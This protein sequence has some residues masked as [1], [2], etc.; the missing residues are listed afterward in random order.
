MSPRSI[1][2]AAAAFVAAAALPQAAGATAAPPASLVAPG[3]P[4]VAVAGGCGI[5]G[6][7]GF[8]GFCRP[9]YYGPAG[10]AFGAPALYGRPFP[11]RARPVYYRPAPALA[12]RRCAVRV[13]PYGAR[14][15]CW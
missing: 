13:T 6:H 8:R 2:F 3:A 15:V 4:V 1:V 10:A 12:A 7:R 5:G 14:R 9:N 11:L